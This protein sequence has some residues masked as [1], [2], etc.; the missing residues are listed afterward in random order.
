MDTLVERLRRLKVF[1]IITALVVLLIVTCAKPPAPDFDIQGHRGARGLYPEN[2]IE[3]FLRAI[4]MG[5]TTLEMDVVVSADSQLVVSHEAFINPAFCNGLAEDDTVN[6]FKLPY[7][8]IAKY[9]CGSKPYARF[10]EQK[11]LKAAKP[12][13]SDV[14]DA[15][16][17][18]I[19]DKGLKPVNYNIETKCEPTGDGVYNPP[20]AAFAKRL[21]DMIKDK[22]IAKRTTLQSFDIRTLQWA[23]KQGVPVTLALLVERTANADSAIKALGFQ[24]DIY[25]SQH[26][27]LNEG[28]ITKLHNENIKVIPWTVNET[29]D[30]QKLINLKVDGIITD[31][32][33][34]LV[35]LIKEK[36]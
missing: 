14:I 21:W 2:S 35:K 19:N 31:Y 10:P 32:P 29:A 9:D 6:I 16:E 8:D 25:S 18:Y 7:A 23:H 22:G 30:M 26:T 34:R 1:A 36:N 13:L 27:F 11:K 28:V 33:D 24:P 15:V 17:K 3:G 5:V 12:L 20:P 4:D